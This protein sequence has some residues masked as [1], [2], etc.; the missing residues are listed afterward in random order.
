MVESYPSSFTILFMNHHTVFISLT[1][2]KQAKGKGKLV[3]IVKYNVKLVKFKKQTS[4]INMN[5]EGCW[6]S[7]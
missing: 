1:W 4:W 6:K 2:L 3:E 5:G 7:L